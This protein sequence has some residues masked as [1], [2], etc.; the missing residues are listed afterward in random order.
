MIILN[1]LFLLATLLP[2]SF[3][4]AGEKSSSRYENVIALAGLSDSV[5]IY[6]DERG[7]PHIY[8]LNEHDLYM[9]VGYVSAQERLWQMDLIRRSTNGK[10]SEIFGKSFLQ[11][12]IISRCLRIPEKSAKILK[13]QD[14]DIIECLQSY[15]DGVNQYINTCKKLPVEFRILSYKPGPWILEDIVNIIGLMGWS[16]GSRNLTAELFNY[17]MVRKLGAEKAA[18]LIPGWDVASEIIYPGFRLNDTLISAVRSLIVSFDQIKNLGVPS[19]SGS[20]NWAVSGTRSITGNPLLSNDMH[21]PFNNPAIWMQMHQVVPGKLNVTGVV[22]PGEPFVVAGH[23]EKIAWG[24]TNLMVDDVDLYTEKINPGNPGQYFFNG[25]WKEMT[26]KEEI[27]RIRGGKQEMAVIRFTHRGPLITGLLNLDHI[28]PKIKWLGYDYLNGLKDLEDLSLSIKWSGY[29]ISDEVKGIYKLNRAKGW[30]DF[31]SGLESFRS[32]SQNFVY[33]DIEGNI[34][35]ITGGGIPVR[36]GNG[37]MI[38]SGETDEYDWQGFVPFDQLPYSFNPPG[39]YVSS[40]NNKTVSGDYPYYISQDFVVP[41]RIRRIREMLEEKELYGTEDFKRMI[42]DQHSVF[43]GLLTPH[44]LKLESRAGELSE[45]EKIVLEDLS[46]WNYNMDPGLYAPSVFEFFRLSF[47][48]N[49]LADELGD[50]YSQLYY[51]TSEYY[52]YKLLTSGIDEWVD[53]INTPQA[54]TLD[55]IV[56]KSFKEG[57]HMLMKQ[58]GKNP[59]KWKWGRIHTITF[60]HPLGSVKILNSFYKLNSH[61]FGIG[62]SDHTVCPYFS[63]KPGFRA[64]QGASIR[65]IYNTA[66]WDDSWS[67]LPGGTSGV[68]G[69]EFYLSQVNTYLEGQFYRDH[70]SEDA[71]KNSAKYKMI[72]KP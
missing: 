28:S 30:E 61:T 48:E 31:R 27:I 72:L 63:I 6:R 55:E 66:D 39:G 53:N 22:I 3:S 47:R 69:S 16:L 54:E 58:Y 43:A 70:F 37:I 57:V 13:D 59:E 62:G 1:F 71:V 11:A 8:A 34:G 41:Y 49:L 33:S 20:N 9:A 12:D 42:T 35:L 68:P 52:V 46:Q 7:M 67:V 45:L 5:I 17:Q 51:M 32:I 26:A 24:M 60:V 23:N 18:S 15:T 21:L 38:R 56:L 14:P 29:D 40:A 2:V 19:F 25:E 4:D 65:H 36:K 44:I 50:L 64:S 10:L